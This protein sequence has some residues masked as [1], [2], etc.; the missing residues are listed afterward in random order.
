MLIPLSPA[1]GSLAKR[2]LRV[3]ARLWGL[4]NLTRN[5]SVAYCTRLTRSLGRCV[6]T[7]S[8]LLLHPILDTLSTH[9]F[10]EVLC[11]EAA[12]VAAAQLSR[13]RVRPHGSEWQ[14]L[15]QHAGYAPRTRLHA[16]PGLARITSSRR[17]VRF[18]HFCPVCQWSR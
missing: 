16:P 9:W 13:T 10:T 14:T 7:S 17:R 2:H 6:S 8:E 4:P 5:L 1:R 11:H 12:H 3:W 15:M 18:E